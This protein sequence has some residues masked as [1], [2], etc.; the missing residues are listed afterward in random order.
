M[1]DTE[2][3]LRH[4]FCSEHVFFRPCTIAQH[5][6]LEEKRVTEII[7]SMESVGVVKKT[8]IVT[9]DNIARYFLP[10]SSKWI[11]R[12]LLGWQR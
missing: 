11:F 10:R 4:M 12:N 5:I 8:S 6:H 1:N 7:E 2:K 3:I 9:G